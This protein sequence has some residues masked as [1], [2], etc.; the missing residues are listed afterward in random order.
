MR[1]SI[2]TN[3]FFVCWLEGGNEML[4]CVGQKMFLPLKVPRQYPLVL[5]VQAYLREGK[6]LGYGKGGGLE[7]GL[8]YE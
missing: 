1:A 7:Y 4:Q 8:R 5:L 2:P 3:D 6:A